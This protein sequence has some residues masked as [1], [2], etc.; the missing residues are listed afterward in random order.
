MPKLSIDPEVADVA[1]ADVELTVYDKQHVVTYMRL[2]AANSEG[3]D[4]RE[5]AY[6]VLHIDP[7][8]EPDRARSA[9]ESHLTRA[10]WISEQGR[11]LRAMGPN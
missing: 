1:P 2:L 6:I 8:R 9:Y 10:K 5:V 7:Y 4:W 3:T 11:L